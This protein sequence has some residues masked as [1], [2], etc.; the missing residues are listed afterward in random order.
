M[1]IEDTR[2]GKTLDLPYH[3]NRTVKKPDRVGTPGSARKA[4]QAA[5][6]LPDRLFGDR[7]VK[8]S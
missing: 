1:A 5:E 8:E 2:A 6:E 7:A 4:K 3:G